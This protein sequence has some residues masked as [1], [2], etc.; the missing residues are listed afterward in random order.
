MP[1]AGG[2]GAAIIGVGAL[3]TLHLMLAMFAGSSRMVVSRFLHIMQR[4]LSGSVGVSV[5]VCSGA[6]V[7][8]MSGV[9]CRR[10]QHV[11][12]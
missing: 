2:Q 10:V 11:C 3:F 8:G 7:S 4:V 1:L 6:C 12:T 5:R 9:L